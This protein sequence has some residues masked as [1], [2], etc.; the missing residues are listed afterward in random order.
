M[1]VA[2]TSAALAAGP[3]TQ[4]VEDATRDLGRVTGL[5]LYCGYSMTATAI[6]E[7][8]VAVVDAHKLTELERGEVGQWYAQGRDAAFA[9]ATSE[10]WDCPLPDAYAAD[11]ARTESAFTASFD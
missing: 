2:G 4:K 7:V 11:V 1:V 3:L 8:V 5:G 10:K 9:F 6:K